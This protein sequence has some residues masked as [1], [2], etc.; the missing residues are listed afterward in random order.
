VVVDRLRCVVPGCRRTAR[1]RTAAATEWI[2]GRHWTA[3]SR[4]WRRRMFLFRRRR[5]WDLAARMWG[6]LRSQAI[7][8]AVGL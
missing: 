5:R 4:V 1:R 8:R 2:C 6:R 3:T 7:E